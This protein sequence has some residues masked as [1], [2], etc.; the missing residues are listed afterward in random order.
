[1]KKILIVLCTAAICLTA[2][3]SVLGAENTST[4]ADIGI[5]V[6][7]PEGWIYFTQQI[8]DDAEG[9]T[10]TGYDAEAL[11]DY[12]K[13]SNIFYNAINM[14]T[15]DEIV[16][17]Y[18]DT[19]IPFKSLNELTEF[20]LDT[21][22]STF[23]SINEAIGSGNVYS[24]EYTISEISG[25]KYLIINFENTAIGLNA[26]QYYTVQN[27]RT[28][29]FVLN[30]FSG[31]ITS[32]LEAVQDSFMNDVVF[33]DA[34]PVIATQTQSTDVSV[35]TATTS[36]VDE[37]SS[38]GEITSQA[39]NTSENSEAE[40]SENEDDKDDEDDIDDKDDEDSESFFEENR[41]IIIIGICGI[42]V[43]IGIAIVV[44]I[45]KK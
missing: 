9:L 33:F 24:E 39:S 30:S 32:E 43:I 7:A 12:F 28:Y 25:I 23:N 38:A 21:I 20:E 15:F 6:K 44:K 14:N 26:R 17:T 35:T 19:V 2:S 3:L 13:S 37:E 22:V 27:N 31:A 40:D 4:I 41:Q 11:E 34:Q 45:S 1:L 42:L 10:L 16:I 5:K 29:N 8:D 36:E 18:V